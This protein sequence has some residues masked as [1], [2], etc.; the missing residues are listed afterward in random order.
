MNRKAK[1]TR[2]EYRSRSV[3]ESLGYRVTRSAGSAGEWDLVA[4]SSKD[5]LLV[6]CKSNRWPNAVE[7][8]AMQ[9]FPAPPNARKIVHL[10]RDRQRLPDVKEL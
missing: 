7:M 6:Q 3:L 8:E 4:I 9:L 5:I 10:W 2:N 1:G